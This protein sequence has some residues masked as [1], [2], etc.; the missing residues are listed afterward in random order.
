MCDISHVQ[1]H[2]VVKEV[3]NQ[4][5]IE[6]TEPFIEPLVLY[7]L[8]IHDMYITKEKGRREE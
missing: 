5:V 8:H 1:V 2:L 3:M 4:E 6:V 7:T